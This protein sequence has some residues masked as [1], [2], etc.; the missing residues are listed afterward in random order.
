[1]VMEQCYNVPPPVMAQLLGEL[2]ASDSTQVRPSK[3]K[4]EAHMKQ[5][6]EPA[7]PAQGTTGEYDAV[8]D[9]ESLFSD[10]RDGDGGVLSS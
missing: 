8:A 5:Q 1:M 6:Q 2:N 4:V 9:A 7:Q 3:R 10:S